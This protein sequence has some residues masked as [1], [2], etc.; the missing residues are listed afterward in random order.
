MVGRVGRAR[1]G[2]GA[3]GVGEHRGPTERRSEVHE[4]SA[5]GK[6]LLITQ[7]VSALADLEL[8]TFLKA[9]K[10]NHRAVDLDRTAPQQIY[11]PY[12]PRCPDEAA[13]EPRNA[14]MWEMHGALGS[15]A[16]EVD[17]AIDRV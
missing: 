2:R 7:P 16:D 11:G 3:A 8:I 9:R 5:R 1:A 15:T 14:R 10:T 13:V 6:R 17:H 4:A 12:P